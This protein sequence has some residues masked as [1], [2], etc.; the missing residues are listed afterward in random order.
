MSPDCVDH[1]TSPSGENLMSQSCGRPRLIPEFLLSTGTILPFL[2]QKYLGWH[3]PNICCV[4]YLE[5]KELNTADTFC[6][7]TGGRPPGGGG[8][9]AF[10]ATGSESENENIWGNHFHFRANGFR[11]GRLAAMTAEAISAN[12]HIPG[13]RL[14]TVKSLTNFPQ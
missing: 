10:K 5:N 6:W 3:P 8:I 7:R 13:P 11:D 12:V 9:A 4:S 2:I 1:G 14:S